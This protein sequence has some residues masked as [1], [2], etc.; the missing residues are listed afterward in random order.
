MNIEDINRLATE[1]ALSVAKGATIGAEFSRVASELD[2]TV[3]EACAFRNEIDGAIQSLLDRQRC[4]LDAVR[5][6][7]L[8]SPPNA[9]GGYDQQTQDG[10][11][12]GWVAAMDKIHHDFL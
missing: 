9:I 11:R 6:V 3:G 12:Q 7:L 4:M 5:G 8:T 1:V 10:F 2:M